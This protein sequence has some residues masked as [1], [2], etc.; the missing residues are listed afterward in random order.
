VSLSA[1]QEAVVNVALP[2]LILENGAVLQLDAVPPITSLEVGKSQPIPT[3]FP[4]MSP[5]MVVPRR[6]FWPLPEKLKC[7]FKVASCESSRVSP[8]AT[9][10]LA[11]GLVVPMPTLPVLVMIILW[12][13]A[14]RDRRDGVGATAGASGLT[15]THGG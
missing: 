6:Q 9:S 1:R 4:A 2:G 10:S 8:L 14:V 5:M 7:V 11:T 12:T 13:F 3:L 15:F